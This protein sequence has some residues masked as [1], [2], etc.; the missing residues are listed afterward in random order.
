[1]FLA[2]KR[3]PVE[4]ARAIGQESGRYNLGINRVGNSPL[5]PIM[6][7]DG[8]R[9]VRTPPA[10]HAHPFYEAVKNRVPAQFHWIPNMPHSMPWYPSQQRQTLNLILDFLGK[11]CGQ[12]SG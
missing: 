7:F 6:L 3:N 1:L 12:I 10:I 11:N 8:D 2:G 9:D 5:L 4:Q